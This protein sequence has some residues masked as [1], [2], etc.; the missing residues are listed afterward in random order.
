K[1]VNLQVYFFFQAEDGIRDRNVTGV[2]TC[3][4]PICNPKMKEAVLKKQPNYWTMAFPSSIRKKS[5]L[6]AISWMTRK[7]CRLPKE[8]INPSAFQRLIPIQH[9][10]K[11]MMR[12]I[13]I[14]NIPLIK[15]Y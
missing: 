4:L 10:F 11:K 5:S 13:T 2:Q 9:L 6:K 14:S 8:K 3:A 7:P 12:T 15:M 1:I